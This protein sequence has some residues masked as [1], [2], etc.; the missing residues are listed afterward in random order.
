GMAAAFEK[1]KAAAKPQDLFIFYYAGHGVINDKN[2]FFLVPYDVTQLY[3]N[4]GARKN[5]FL[6][7]ITPW[8]A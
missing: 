6:S 4:D 3:G 1:V 8:P 7:F 5:W 2:Q